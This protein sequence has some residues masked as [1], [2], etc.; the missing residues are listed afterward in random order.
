MKVNK[1]KIKETDISGRGGKEKLILPILPEGY[2]RVSA[3]L[4][5]FLSPDGKIK[6]EIKKQQNLQ[7]F[8]IGKYSNLSEED[9]K[10]I[11]LF[12]NHKKG[13]I[14]NIYSIPLGEM[15]DLLTSD[16]KYRVWGWTKENIKLCG[17]QKKKF[18]TMQVKVQLKVRSTIEKYE[19]HFERVF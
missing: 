11:M 1:E 14:E 7:W 15:L 4:Y 5:D 17:E 10:I 8:D 16:Q 6:I 3:A 19:K 2:K 18:S 9:L 13:K 12:I